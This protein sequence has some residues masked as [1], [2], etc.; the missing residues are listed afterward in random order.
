M[1]KKEAVKLPAE[2]LVGD[3]P[4]S[5][6]YYEVECAVFRLKPD[7]ELEVFINQTGQWTRDEGDV[8]RVF[9]HSTPMSLEDVRPYMD[10]EPKD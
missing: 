9:R 5:I 8:S 3:E 2:M 10:R 1:R 4:M 6:K 7:T